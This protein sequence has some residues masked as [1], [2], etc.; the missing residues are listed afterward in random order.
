VIRG[1]ALAALIVF[2]LTVPFAAQVAGSA[3]PGNDVAPQ[4]SPDGRWLIFERLYGR[5]R[6]VPP[7]ESLRIVDAAGRATDREL[8]PGTSAR[9][10]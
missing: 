2:A 1:V 6:Y 3:Q 9:T 8:V 7:D 5:S 4:A 10:V